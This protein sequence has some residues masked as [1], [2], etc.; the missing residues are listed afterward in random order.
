MF[1][2]EGDLSIAASPSAAG[3]AALGLRA[4]LCEARGRQHL[5]EHQHRKNDHDGADDEFS[6]RELPTHQRPENDP[7][8]SSW[9]PPNRIPRSDKSGPDGYFAQLRSGVTIPDIVMLS[10]ETPIRGAPRADL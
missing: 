3:N 5:P 6:Q 10:L 9:Q 8:V 1:P 4:S 7:R 2:P